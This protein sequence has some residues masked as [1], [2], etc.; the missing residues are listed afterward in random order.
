MPKKRGEPSAHDT[1]DRDRLWQ[2]WN[3]LKMTLHEV[4]DAWLLAYT[5]ISDNNEIK[6]Q[7]DPH[8]LNPWNLR[9]RSSKA[10]T[11]PRNIRVS[12]TLG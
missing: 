3:D 6:Y 10:W 9:S 11:F 5:E 12:G 1:W 2:F 8:L 4:K 7:A